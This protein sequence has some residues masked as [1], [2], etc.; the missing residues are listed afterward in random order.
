MI[1]VIIALLTASGT[2]VFLLSRWSQPGIAQGAGILAALAN[3]PGGVD[4]GMA[5]LLIG[6][7]LAAVIAWKGLA[8]YYIHWVFRDEYDKPRKASQAVMRANELPLSPF[9]KR[10]LR[11]GIAR[12]FCLFLG[13]RH[14]E[15][16]KQQGLL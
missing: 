9:M 6:S 11:R 15:R 3:A 7:A 4:C 10:K 16:M 13:R 12:Q 14:N 2:S 8:L 5:I 1:D